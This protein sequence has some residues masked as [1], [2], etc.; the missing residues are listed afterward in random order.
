VGVNEASPTAKLHI[1]GSD[2]TSSNFTMKLDNSSSSPLLYARNDGNVGIGT[3]TPA[4]KLDVNGDSLINGLTVGRGGGDS[5]FNVALGN[6]AL[7]NNN[8]GARNTA[9]GY[10]SSSSNVT[11]NGNTSVGYEALKN[12]TGDSNV[13]I[14][15][16][17]LP[18]NST[19]SGNVGVGRYSLGNNT[20]GSSNIAIGSGVGTLLSNTNGSQNIAIGGYAMYSQNGV[21][22]SVA[23]G[24]ASQYL[25]TAGAGN[26]SIGFESLR[27][28][29]SNNNTA[30]GYQAGRAHTTGNNN[31]FI[32]N[33]ADSSAIGVTNA[34]A[35][36][37]DTK[38]S[39]SNTMV[40]GNGVNVGIGTSTPT[41]KLQVVG[42]PTY[43]NNAAAITG[44]L[45]AG[46]LYIRTGHGLDIVV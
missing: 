10:Y 42:L 27:E 36:G 28:V 4:K 14:G 21:N 24:W 13:A 1:K 3:S 18:S 17:S 25:N 23:I 16:E 46:A 31:T 12:N 35:I 34:T 33:L 26:T 2:S 44:G 40:L 43:A 9:V 11:G 30:L 15:S 29:T 38:V 39:Q 45:T 22:G 7:A 20:T 32:G 41:S 37:Y 5:M 8:G 6:N 19:G